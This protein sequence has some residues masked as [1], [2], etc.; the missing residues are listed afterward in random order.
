M[1]RNVSK[2]KKGGEG[3]EIERNIRVVLLVCC[4]QFCLVV[5]CLICFGKDKWLVKEG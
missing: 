2:Q 5:D 4:C 1:Y 3:E